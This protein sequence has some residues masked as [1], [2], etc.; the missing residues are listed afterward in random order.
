MD[1]FGIF[2]LARPCD[3]T[4]I[5]LSHLISVYNWNHDTVG[6]YGMYLRYRGP[7]GTAVRSR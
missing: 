4:L 5:E 7:V 3:L 2:V 1:V 6:T